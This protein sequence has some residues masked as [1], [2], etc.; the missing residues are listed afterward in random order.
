MLADASQDNCFC[1]TVQQKKLQVV[2][3]A[4]THFDDKQWDNPSLELNIEKSSNDLQRFFQKQ[5]PPSQVEFHILQSRDETTHDAI[6]DF[7]RGPFAKFANGSVTLFFVLSHGIPKSTPNPLFTQDLQIVTSDTGYGTGDR[8][9]SVAKD[10][11]PEFV[12]LTQPGS[13]VLAFLDTCYSGSAQ[14]LSMSLQKELAQSFGLRIMMM[15]SSLPE[16]QSYRATFTEA[17]LD[18]WSRPTVGSS[19]T[20][21]YQAPNKLRE[22]I[23]H[24]LEPQPLGPTEGL[25]KVVVP[26]LGNFC[27]ESFSADSGLVVFFNRLSHQV[28]ALIGENPNSLD[29]SVPM[30][31]GEIIPYRLSRKLYTLDVV[32]NDGQRDSSAGT[33]PQ[34]VDL[35]EY[36]VS[37]ELLGPVTPDELGSAYIKTSSYAAAAGLPNDTVV[38]YQKRAFASFASAHL[39]EKALDVASTIDREALPKDAGHGDKDLYVSQHLAFETDWGQSKGT[40]SGMK[41]EDLES[42]IERELDVAALA[43]LEK[44][45]G[46]FAAAGDY[47][48]KAATLENSNMDKR[49]FAE[50]AYFAYGAVNQPV[51]AQRIRQEYDLRIETDCPDCKL[52]EQSATGSGTGESAHA[53][54]SACV[55]KLLLH[56]EY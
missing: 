20:S 32:G 5:F 48:A 30:M 4:V 25:P 36:P 10:L 56:M 46:R 22:S 47:Y 44:L 28:A 23:R 12:A 26:Y 15:A 37:F 11:F 35:N 51:K 1:Q 24:Q 52:M 41:R 6:E 27:M 39:Q 31:Q 34:A 18:L 40:K 8:S 38:S 33:F 54:A 9:F 49:K 43:R 50:Q 45:A 29:S 13:I 42:I 55:V 21:E 17:L 14:D 19:C 53:F 3:V 2:V 7:L 16:T